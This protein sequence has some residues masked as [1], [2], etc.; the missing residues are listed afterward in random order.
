MLHTKHFSTKMA[1]FSGMF[2]C[3][4]PAKQVATAIQLFF[5][6]LPVIFVVIRVNKTDCS[7]E[8]CGGLIYYFFYCLYWLQCRRLHNTAIFVRKKLQQPG[9]CPWI[10]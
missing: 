3:A 7:R 6:Q 8:C 2:R 9:L 4:A 1:D 5:I 10:R